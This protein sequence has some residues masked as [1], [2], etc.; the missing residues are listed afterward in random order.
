MKPIRLMKTAL[1]KR[2]EN[3]NKVLKIENSGEALKVLNQLINEIRKYYRLD[4][5]E[6]SWCNTFYNM[7]YQELRNYILNIQKQEKE[8][9]NLQE[10]K[11]EIIFMKN[12]YGN[13][14]DE[15]LSNDGVILKD[16]INIIWDELLLHCKIFKS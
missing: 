2:N 10:L 8:L 5:N 13:K 16:A 1:V 3:M 6:D 15:D 12:M 4:E 7:L 14:K 9:K 11:E